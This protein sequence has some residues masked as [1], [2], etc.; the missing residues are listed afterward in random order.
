M[1]TGILYKYKSSGAP[2]RFFYT[3]M[4]MEFEDTYS[5]MYFDEGG[6]VWVAVYFCVFYEGENTFASKDVRFKKKKNW[7]II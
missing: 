7:T 3:Y 2:K 1:S 5:L 6:E 4:Y